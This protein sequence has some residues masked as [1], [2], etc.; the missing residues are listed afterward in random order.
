M[1]RGDWQLP[2]ALQTQVKRERGILPTGHSTHAQT[3]ARKQ[4]TYTHLISP[5]T[6]SLDSEDE[7]FLR[8]HMP[9]NSRP[10]P[11]F[12]EDENAFEDTNQNHMLSFRFRRRRIPSKTQLKFTYLKFPIPKKKDTFDDNLNF[13]DTFHEVFRHSRLT[14]QC[15]I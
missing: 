13:G 3:G 6:F 5:T 7:A 2:P 4:H 12:S 15:C 1:H 9:R 14:C 8:R 10:R 11:I